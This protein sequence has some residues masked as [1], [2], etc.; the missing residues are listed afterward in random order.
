MFIKQFIPLFQAHIKYKM[1]KRENSKSYKVL[2]GF[3][4]NFQNILKIFPNKTL[5]KTDLAPFDPRSIILTIF[6]ENH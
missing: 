4:V 6:V 2:E 3:L 5:F 1:L